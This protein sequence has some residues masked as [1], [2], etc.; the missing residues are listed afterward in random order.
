[1]PLRVRDEE[2]AAP[3]ACNTG[4]LAQKDQHCHVC[5]LV[6]ESLFDQVVACVRHAGH[7]L[8]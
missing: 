7:G 8:M 4:G 1:M 6:H 5:R 2:N 3:Q